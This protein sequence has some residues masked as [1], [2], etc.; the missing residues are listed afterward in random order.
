MRNG[1]HSGLNQILS[2]PMPTRIAS[3]DWKSGSSAQNGT[4]GPAKS[5]LSKSEVNVLRM[6]AMGHSNNAIAAKLQITVKSVEKYRSQ[7][8][9]KL[10]L[11]NRVE[12][13]RHATSRGWVK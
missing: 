1:R 2:M 6:V 7:S 13:L 5:N 11:R 3:T 4:L 8:M 10:G 12:V 9:Q